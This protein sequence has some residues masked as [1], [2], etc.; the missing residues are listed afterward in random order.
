MCAEFSDGPFSWIFPY[1]D[2]VFGWQLYTYRNYRV[3]L[4]GTKLNTPFPSPVNFDKV[5]VETSLL[6]RKV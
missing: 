6:P 5:F 2:H 4:T 3:S 1:K